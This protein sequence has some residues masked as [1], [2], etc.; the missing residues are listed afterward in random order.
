MQPDRREPV[1]P[2]RSPRKPARDLG[3]LLPPP[4]AQ[5][6]LQPKSRGCGLERARSLARERW[7]GHH[8]IARP[9]RD[10]R[11]P[12]GPS[13]AS[14]RR[15]STERARASLVSRF[16][17]LAL[18]VV[19]E[20]TARVDLGPAPRGAGERSRSEARPSRAPRGGGSTQKHRAERRAANAVSR[21][22]DGAPQK[23]RFLRGGGLEKPPRK[24][25]EDTA[26]CGVL[27]GGRRPRGPPF[28]GNGIQPAGRI[29]SVVAS[30]RPSG[31]WS[32]SRCRRG[33]VCA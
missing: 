1:P 28:W 22:G 14:R 4:A 24:K 25:R 26:P 19:P 3:K 29:T 18:A 13:A 21:L 27:P 15:W 10:R 12:R 23:P 6:A 16:G 30:R 5:V 17:A 31:R 20:P 11:A 7:K 8:S 9:P 32:T 33:E 2:S